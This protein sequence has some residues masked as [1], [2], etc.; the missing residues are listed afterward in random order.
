MSLLTGITGSLLNC[1]NVDTHFFWID[2]D[3]ICFYNQYYLT[4]ISHRDKCY[5]KG[6]KLGNTLFTCG[7]RIKHDQH[8]GPAWRGASLHYETGSMVLS[9]IPPPTPKPTC[10]L[11]LMYYSK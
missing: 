6:N 7:E 4:L 10:Q 1:R 3:G 2:A 11:S 5:M 9:Y 8:T